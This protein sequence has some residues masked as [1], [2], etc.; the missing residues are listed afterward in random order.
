MTATGD[1]LI[2]GELYAIAGNPSLDAALAAE[3]PDEGAEH[4]FVAADDL[5][6]AMR[7]DGARHCVRTAR[8]SWLR[9]GV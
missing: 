6:A 5:R 2:K 3:A 9:I 1:K 4:P 7:K 8:S